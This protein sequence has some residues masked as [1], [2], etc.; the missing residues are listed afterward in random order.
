MSTLSTCFDQF[1]FS[2]FRF[3]GRPSYAV[4]GEGG[5]RSV[6]TNSY[7]RRVALAALRGQAWSRVR[8]VDDPVTGYQREEL[9]RVYLES[10]ACGEDVSVVRR[11]D[12]PDD[13]MD[14][15]LFDGGYPSAVAVL[16]RFDADGAPTED[17]LVTD[18]DFLD[19]LHADAVQLV[20][21]SVGLG[22]YLAGVD[23]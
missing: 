18:P 8:V 14:F 23:A 3:E 7:L 17:E 12:M 22:E 6:R 13:L 9:D 11:A 4:S 16:L 15:W 10:H 1:R 20:A 5:L 2:A 21:M 19:E